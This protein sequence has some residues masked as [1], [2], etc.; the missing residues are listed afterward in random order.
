MAHPTVWH[1]ARQLMAPRTA[2]A[3]RGKMGARMSAGRKLATRTGL[4]SSSRSPTPQPRSQALLHPRRDVGAGHQPQRRA[5]H[6]RDDV[7]DAARE[8]HRAIVGHAPDA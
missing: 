1:S 6:H 4:M 5:G 3:T 8:E 7:Q 2:S